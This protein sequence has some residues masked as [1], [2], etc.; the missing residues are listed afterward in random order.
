MKIKD[1]SLAEALIE[2]KKEEIIT[3]WQEIHG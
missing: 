1:L 3:K 2:E